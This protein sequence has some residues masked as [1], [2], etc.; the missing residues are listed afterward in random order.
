MLCLH[1]WMASQQSKSTEWT[2]HGRALEGRVTLHCAAPFSINFERIVTAVAWASPIFS[3]NDLH[4]LFFLVQSP[5]NSFATLPMF[6]QSWQDSQLFA[7][8]CRDMFGLLL[9]GTESGDGTSNFGMSED[10]GLAANCMGHPAGSKSPSSSSS[11][12]NA[13]G[14]ALVALSR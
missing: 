8:D 11:E 1:P 4:Q 9:M 12:D 14:F 5:L 7:D 2:F 13:G 10:L 3:C 6:S